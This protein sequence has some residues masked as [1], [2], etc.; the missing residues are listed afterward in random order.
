VT[1][2]NVALRQS[3]PALALVTKSRPTAELTPEERDALMAK[4][5]A[6][7]RELGKKIDLEKLMYSYAD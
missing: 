7:Q 4:H 1:A 5:V 3:A 6:R 2:K